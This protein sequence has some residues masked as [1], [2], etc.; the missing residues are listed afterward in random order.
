MATKPA[1]ADSATA[2]EAAH[3]EWRP[4]TNPWLIAATVYNVTWGT[5]VLLF[6]NA[7]FDVL[8]IA[9]PN[10]PAI[11]QVVGLFVLLYA[12][13]YAAAAMAPSR[14]LLLVAIAFL[15]KLAG[16]IGFAIGYLTASLPAAFGLVVLT[17]DV[18]W[19]PFFVAYFAALRRS[20]KTG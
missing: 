3:A 6:P 8:G 16:P 7:L 17:N 15:G 19:W 10:Y 13:A 18:V 11:W 9:R 1:V 20:S 14:G 2:L 4:R 5:A 12:P